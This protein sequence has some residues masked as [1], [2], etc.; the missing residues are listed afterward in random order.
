MLEHVT[1]IK[2]KKN[3]Y[4]FLAFDLG[5]DI[6]PSLKKWGGLHLFKVLP[7]KFI[8]H[9]ILNITIIKM[10]NNFTLFIRDF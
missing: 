4:N 10:Q 5:F 9:Q 3:L 8:S 7:N 6:T 1:L 2:K